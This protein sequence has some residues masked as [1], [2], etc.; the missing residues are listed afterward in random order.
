MATSLGRCRPSRRAQ[1]P[2][3]Q[4]SRPRASRRDRLLPPPGA[5]K[6]ASRLGEL[7]EYIDELVAG[8]VWIQAQCHDAEDTR[9][10]T[11]NIA[12]RVEPGCERRTR[13][14]WPRAAHEETWANFV[15]L[16]HFDESLSAN[17]P[18]PMAAQSNS[19]NYSAVQDQRDRLVITPSRGLRGPTS[20]RGL[21]MSGRGR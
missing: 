16:D 4:R 13:R 8:Q 19:K 15:L 9:Y 3:P 11:A 20:C 18:S 12:N 10:G 2:G 5:S 14:G 17:Q 6:L 21:H 1:R 7:S